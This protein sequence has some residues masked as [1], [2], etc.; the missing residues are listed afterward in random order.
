MRWGIRQIGSTAIRDVVEK[1]PRVALVVSGHVHLCGGRRDRLGRAVVLNAASNDKVG[2]PAKIATLL[3]R[4]GGAVENFRWTELS[5][6]F[7][8]AEISGIGGKY[9]ARL[10]QAGIA[11]IEHLA[12]A[13][14]DAVGQ[15]LGWRQRPEKAA[16]FIARARALLEGQPSL[17]S[18]PQLPK[19]P[20]LYL[21]IETDLQQSYT[22]LVGVAEEEGDEVHQFFASHPSEEGDMLRE[23]AV[24]LKARAGHSLVHF[25]GFNFDRNVIVRRMES[26]GIVTPVPLLQSIDCLPELRRSLALPTKGMGLKEAVECLG[27]RFAHPDLDGFGVAYE[28]QKAIQAGSSVPERL[29]MYNRD[30]VLALRFL[31]REV[32]KLAATPPRS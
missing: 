29:L 23:L 5:S 7:Q 16:I 24:F 3:L 11:T 12:V 2:S 21:D 20:R 28:Y 9:A 4:T 32:E 22:W 8:I 26:H 18:V 14:P 31:I 13:T 10:A 6:S 27:Y 25:S 30:D 1:D 17:L 19:K 15:A